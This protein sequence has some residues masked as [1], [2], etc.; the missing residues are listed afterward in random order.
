MTLSTEKQQVKE[1]ESLLDEVRKQLLDAQ[2]H[3]DIWEQLWPTEENVHI[4]NVYRGFFQ[5]TRIAHLDRFFIKA[6]NVMSNDPTSPS[7]YR[8]L[9]MIRKDVNLAPG[10]EL[11]ALRNRLKKQKNLI[12]RIRQYR[13]KRAA[14]WD[15]EVT[16]RLDGEKGCQV[17][18]LCSSSVVFSL[19]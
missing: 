6:S 3:F 17:A 1:F 2:I 18:S 7:F 4:I 12:E 11:R 9:N 15:T 5:P 16:G 10:I 13:N 8:V 14:H 19:A